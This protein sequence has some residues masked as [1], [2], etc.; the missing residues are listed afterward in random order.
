MLPSVDRK[1]G[2]R[3][4]VLLAQS[5]TVKQCLKLSLV[6]ACALF[7][8]LHSKGVHLPAG[9]RAL[10]TTPHHTTPPRPRPT[11]SNLVSFWPQMGKVVEKWR[12][13]Q[14]CKGLPPLLLESPRYPLYLVQPVQ[15]SL[16]HL[17]G[18]GEHRPAGPCSSPP[19][20][21]LNLTLTLQNPACHPPSAPFSSR[22]SPLPYI[23]SWY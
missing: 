21:P 11:L 20:R 3:E 19:D 9:L 17:Q 23:P 5:R 6:K 22:P 13:T 10:T 1:R 16:V 4:V 18:V 15:D 8:A 12:G 2:L 14:A 7:A